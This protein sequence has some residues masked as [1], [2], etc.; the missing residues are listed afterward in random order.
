MSYS[1]S[2]L[3]CTK[4]FGR[5]LR[6]EG[7]QCC[8]KS[9]AQVDIGRVRPSFRQSSAQ[10]PF[11]AR[12]CKSIK[13]LRYSSEVLQ[14]CDILPWPL[15]STLWVSGRAA[16]WLGGHK[17]G[18]CLYRSMCIITDPRESK[19]SGKKRS[20]D[21]KSLDFDCFSEILYFQTLCCHRIEGNIWKLVKH[22]L[23]D[24]FH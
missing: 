9:S 7:Y 11:F 6:N 1:N 23:R 4:C 20:E 12:P 19:N 16:N 3:S 13:P 14:R 24:L 10:M 2:Q 21:G 18:W 17:Q 8:L 5:C 15:N 22:C